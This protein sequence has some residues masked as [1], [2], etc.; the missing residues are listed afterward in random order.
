MPGNNL[1]NTVTLRFDVTGEERAI[2]ATRNLGD[3]AASAARG[4]SSMQKGLGGF[5]GAYAGAAAT[6][7]ALQQG[8]SALKESAKLEQSVQGTKTLASAIGQSGD[9]ILS[10]IKLITRG[11]LTL[12]DA[13]ESANLALASG[14][15]TDQIQRLTTIATKASIAL[16]RD[17]GDSFS[18]LVKGS[19]KLEPEL[20]DELGL[21][22]RIEPAVQAYA[23]QIG[24]SEKF[25]TNFERRQ[26]FVNAVMEEGERKFNA[27]SLST[28]TPISSLEKLAA[29]IYDIGLAI[30]GVLA[31]SFQPFA[32]FIS[33]SFANSLSAVGLIASLAFAKAGQ[34][35]SG[36]LHNS[37]QGIT[38]WNN[39]R[40]AAIRDSSGISKA[41]SEKLGVLSTG[42]NH[43]VSGTVDKNKTEYIKA[44]ADGITLKDSEL[45]ELRLRT[46]HNMAS[47]EEIISKIAIRSK[48]DP[49]ILLGAVKSFRGSDFQDFREHIGNRMV[50]DGLRSSASGHNIVSNKDLANLNAAG[51]SFIQDKRMSTTVD[52]HVAAQGK[53]GA[54]YSFTSSALSKTVSGISTA[55]DVMSRWTGRILFVITLVELF[56]S[57]LL[58]MTGLTPVFD[59]LVKGLADIGANMFGLTKNAESFK[60]TMSSI[61]DIKLGDQFKRVGLSN[62]ATPTFEGIFGI[63][64]DQSQDE[65]KKNLETIITKAYKSIKTPEV[66]DEYGILI[67]EAEFNTDNYVNTLQKEIDKLRELVPLNDSAVRAKRAMIGALQDLQKLNPGA[68][69]IVKRVSLTTGISQAELA[70]NLSH[71][72][73]ITATDKGVGL[74]L[75][76]GG[77]IFLEDEAIL[78]KRQDL[79]RRTYTSQGKAA[80]GN[81]RADEM[82]EVTSVQ[83]K[84]IALSSKRLD[85]EK[86]MSE[87]AMV[88]QE[89]L[90]QQESALINLNGE[91]E[92]QIVLLNVRAKLEGED[93]TKYQ[94]ALETLALEKEKNRQILIQSRNTGVVLVRHDQ[95]LKT[96]SAEMNIIQE[97]NG[98]L[99]ANGTLAAQ[100]QDI[101]KNQLAD[102]EATASLADKFNEKS[103]GAEKSAFLRGQAALKIMAGMFIKHTEDVTTLNNEFSKQAEHITGEYLITLLNIKKVISEGLVVEY[104]FRIKNLELTKEASIQQAEIASRA[105]VIALQQ[106]EIELHSNTNR[107][108][109][110]K[111]LLEL[112]MKLRDSQV[113]YN[114]AVREGMTLVR[115]KP[116]NLLSEVYNAFPDLSTDQQKREIKITLDENKLRDFQSSVREQIDVINKNTADKNQQ[117]EIEKSIAANQ[118]KLAQN[119]AAQDNERINLEVRK[120]DEQLTFMREERGIR[121]KIWN[122]QKELL[123]IETDIAKSRIEM[124]KAVK[125]AEFTILDR[126]VD[127]LSIEGKMLEKHVVDIA[128]V[129]A[130]Q[131]AI[132]VIGTPLDPLQHLPEYQNE[133]DPQKQLKL[134]ADHFSK[135]FEAEVQSRSGATASSLSSLKDSYAL[136]KENTRKNF[137]SG[138]ELQD[139]QLD[140]KLKTMNEEYNLYVRSSVAQEQY[141]KGL[142]ANLESERGLAGARVEDAANTYKETLK[143]IDLEKKN[144]GIVSETNKQKLLNDEMSM[145]FELERAKKLNELANNPFFQFMVDLG[146]IVK[147]DFTKGL[148]DLNEAFITGTLTMENFKAG[149]KDFARTLVMDIEKALVQR[150][151]INPIT[152]FAQ[153]QLG[154]ITKDLFGLDMGKPKLESTID[155]SAPGGPAIRV[156]IPGMTIGNTPIGSPGV[157]G[158]GASAKVPEVPTAEAYGLWASETPDKR[159]G[160]YS[161]VASASE[162]SAP[163]EIAAAA[164]AETDKASSSWKTFTSDFKNYG[165]A[166]TGS[167]AS[168]I[169]SGGNFKNAM[170]GVFASLFAQIARNMISGGISA[171]IPGL[172]GLFSGIGAGFSNI[173]GGGSWSSAA[174]G[175][176]STVPD[177]VAAGGAAFASGGLV[178]KMSTGGSIYGLASGGTGIPFGRDTVPTWL[179]PG[180][181]VMRKSAVENIGLSRLNRMNNHGMGTGDVQVNVTNMGTAQD[182][183]GKPK[184]KWNGQKMIV[185][186]IVKDLD[187]NGPIRQSLRGAL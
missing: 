154:K 114:Q 160:A 155:M 187:N 157:V 140:L 41:V 164:K 39:K 46:Q 128:K 122:E 73:N 125:E 178:R 13:A 61:A 158:I 19:A 60:N 27:L 145:R 24:K 58:K 107:L 84:I 130:Q 104:Q 9:T 51:W 43:A 1:T 70:R 123:K 138:L 72:K 147:K 69:D 40:Q 165:I 86:Y 66:R 127:L 137:A 32:D 18:R 80:E 81:T 50:L 3:N 68:L 126:R 173:A 133:A 185:D 49:S 121:E 71:F 91:L 112:G 97:I 170:I 47:Q 98:Y 96:F 56:G 76:A 82:G 64:S 141:Q 30:G 36:F 15:N 149:L 151:I 177:Y 117:F 167:F 83:E 75:P 63:S 108:N 21:F 74:T 102:L 25:L 7:F 136:I 156:S 5:V 179:E 168:I 124:E 6:F 67:Q 159:M 120:I 116:I 103:T 85:L 161:S 55:I 172:G 135:P 65:L 10:Q 146:G 31:H 44:L 184:V 134:L 111:E 106:A 4:F 175:V 94:S 100:Q 20:L 89:G 99:N 37:A 143:K 139:K 131:N 95:L 101:R 93:N 42:Y 163:S 92:K 148:Q 78:K 57:L 152:D 23:A 162:A 33:G 88:T 182:V 14:F 113:A 38:E 77:K 109:A 34:V 115:D 12:K 171:G 87:S 110:Q 8:F 28:S 45:K 150:V 79:I 59:T 132:A 2:Q 119:Q 142:K 62:T 144:T 54:A 52:D 16:G 90:A 53:L 186:I 174:A 11:Q 176:G 48:L 183:E 129:F 169:A 35:F 180:E 29:S 118:F 153:E 22:T 181:F 17:L 26:A 166:L 105:R